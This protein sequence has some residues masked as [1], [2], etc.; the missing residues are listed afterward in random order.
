MANAM[1]ALEGK[2]NKPK[3]LRKK[4]LVLYTLGPRV[5]KTGALIIKNK[6]A[7]GHFLKVFEQVDQNPH[8]DPEISCY[9]TM[10][11]TWNTINLTG[12]AI[13]DATKLISLFF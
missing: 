6:N 10:K 13:Q 2:T 5:C 4:C 7:N 9:I 11:S 1:C 12:N 3:I 8:L